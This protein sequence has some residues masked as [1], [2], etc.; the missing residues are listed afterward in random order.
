[1]RQARELEMKKTLLMAL[2]GLGAIWSPIVQADETALAGDAERGR[3]LF[4]ACRTCHYP[5]SYVGNHNGP[6]LHAIFGR[7]AGTRD[8]FEYYSAA[9]KSAQFVWTPALLDAWMA[10]PDDFLPGNEMVF[11]PPRTAQERADLIEYLKGFG[12]P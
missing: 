9:L 11:V 2:C 12:E 5:E 8:G 1:M 3:Q 10:N 7:A 4:G 6:S